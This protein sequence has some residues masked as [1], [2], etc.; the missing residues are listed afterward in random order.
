MKP[1]VRAITAIVALAAT[2][3]SLAAMRCG[4]R[5]ITEGDTA[6]LLTARC[7]PPAEITQ[8]TILRPPVIW[9][10]GRPY[11]V[12]GGEIEA[13]ILTGAAD[14]GDKERARLEKELADAE[15]WLVAAQARL[16]N[17]GFVDKAPPP[18]VEG[19]RARAR[20]LEDQVA[21]LRERLAR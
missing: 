18:V 10:H 17:D 3:P 16:A 15:G 5:L 21:R 9:R 14:A 8:Q 2:T 7:G 13:T 19:A 4:N 6:G 1:A 12:P 20:E 11:H